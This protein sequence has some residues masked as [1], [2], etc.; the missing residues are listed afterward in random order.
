[1]L[2]D[3]KTETILYDRFLWKDPIGMKE[4]DITRT[5]T[6]TYIEENLRD[7]VDH[8]SLGA[9]IEFSYLTFLTVSTYKPNTL[10]IFN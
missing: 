6:E 1:M 2:Y 10:I 8:M 9:S 5:E 7:R 3:A 4:A